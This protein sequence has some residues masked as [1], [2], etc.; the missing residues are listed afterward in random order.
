[1]INAQI[2]KIFYQIAEYYAMKE[3]AFK[4]QAYERAARLIESMEDDLVVVYERGRLKALMELPGVGQGMAE[5]IEEFIKTGKIKEYLRLKE[6]TPV[7]LEELSAISGLGPKTISLLYKKLKIK[8]VD[9]LQKAAK[10]GKLRD[11]PRLGEKIEQNILRGI[12]FSKGDRGRFLL[13]YILPLARKI[14]KR[15]KDQDFISQALAAGSV[16]RRK[17]TIGDL[18]FL[19]ISSNP[20]KAMDYFCAMGEVEKVMAKGETKSVVRLETGLNADIRVVPEESFGAALQYFTGNKDHNIELR[21]IAEKKGWKLNEYGIF[22]G[23]KQLAG[24]TEE[25][26]YEKLGLQWMEPELRENTGEIEAALKNK[27]PK[28]VETD[29][30]KGDLQMHSTWSDGTQSIKEMAEAAR[31]LGYE[32]I[33]ITDHTGDLRIA[34]GLDEKAL[35]KYMAEI[36][37]ADKELAGF[38]ILKGAEVNIRKDGTLDVSDKILA[39]LDIVLAAVHSSFKMPRAEMTKRIIRAMEN[40][41]VNVIVH[42]TGR[43]IQK[44]EGYEIDFEEILKAAKRTGT[45]LEINAY[46]DRLDLN[47]VHIKKAIEAQVKLSIGTDSHSKIQLPYLE[48]GVAQARR[49]WA[50]KKDIINCLGYNELVE[51]LRKKK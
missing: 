9:D 6:K 13:G 37:R 11:L 31:E 23:K 26:V 43:V 39:K 32:Y 14:E 24:E 28:L 4:P 8:T 27:L 45:A 51:F 50:T 2:A 30:I 46:P 17:E 49:G 36:E 40:P 18:D 21:K 19:V 12:E 3:V 25:E 16:R 29:D 35:L 1:M 20:Q 22:S 48:L 33:A 41:N 34:G 5:K 10:A 42:P 15:L 7:N 38:R 47:D 44:R